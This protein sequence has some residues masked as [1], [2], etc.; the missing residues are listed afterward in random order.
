MERP[1][2]PRTQYNTN[3]RSHVAVDPAQSQQSL[4]QPQSAGGGGGVLFAQTPEVPY[5]YDSMPS[6]YRYA[7][8]FPF[9]IVKQLNCFFFYWEIVIPT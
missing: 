1:Q 4:I 5:G 8:S 2:Y 3:N 7:F 6:N 9:K